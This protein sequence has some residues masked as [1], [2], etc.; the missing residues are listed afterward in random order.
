MKKKSHFSDDELRDALREYYRSQMGVPERGE[1]DPAFTQKMLALA[2][3]EL[4]REQSAQK[5]HSLNHNHAPAHSFSLPRWAK[6]TASFLL[7]GALSGGLVLAASPTARAYFLNWS[8]IFGDGYTHYRMETDG[9]EFE[10]I[11]YE[12]TWIPDG[13]YEISRKINSSRLSIAYEDDNG[14]RIFFRSITDPN[15]FALGINYG[16][17]TELLPVVINGNPGDLYLEPDTSQ[18]SGIVW[19][20]DYLTFTLSGSLTQ[21]ELMKIAESI[22]IIK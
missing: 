22:E 15:S 17:D 8:K 18:L 4:K 16:D 1:S 7:V 3:E 14:G 12:P 10:K 2:E 21:Q 11:Y 20:D 5:L 19:T 6:R 9:E 13:Y